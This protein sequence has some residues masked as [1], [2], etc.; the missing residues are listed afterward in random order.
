[1]G[2]ACLC[3]DP[4]GQINLE[5]PV[6]ASRSSRDPFLFLGPSVGVHRHGDIQMCEAFPVCDKSLLG[7]SVGA[8]TIGGLHNVLYCLVCDLK[9]CSPTTL[10][11]GDSSDPMAVRPE[12]VLLQTTLSCS[13]EVIPHMSLWV[14]SCAL[15][16]SC[17][18]VVTFMD[19]S[20]VC[21]S[22]LS[23]SL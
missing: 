9:S 15:A 1:M 10:Q 8:D 5:S 23:S 19:M 17:P 18:G 2:H 4:T 3:K 12:G 14:L 20:Y 16:V 21:L 11:A 7:L 6:F 13:V 22:Y